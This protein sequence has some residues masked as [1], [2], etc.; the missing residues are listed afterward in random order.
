MFFFYSLSILEGLYDSP[1]LHASQMALVP[2]GILYHPP[3]KFADLVAPLHPIQFQTLWGLRQATVHTLSL[4]A[5]RPQ[6][7][8]LAY[9]A[10]IQL[11]KVENED[12]TLLSAPMA[13]LEAAAISALG[14]E[15][16][17]AW[18]KGLP[19]SF[20]HIDALNPDGCDNDVQANPFGINFTMAAWLHTISKA[21]G[22]VA[23]AKQ[24]YAPYV[25]NEKGWNAK[26][27]AGETAEDIID[28]WTWTPGRSIGATMASDKPALLH[29]LRHSAVG[30]KKM[31]EVLY[32]VH[33]VR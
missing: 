17:R 4:G 24:R 16:W 15:W 14:D 31:L 21:W 20:G 29:T 9:S 8:D 22:F 32:Q 18:Y 6:D 11:G 3:K 5:A 28:S 19:D 1:T 27:E 23:Y 25:N 7:F 2:Q 30:A 12:P 13:K 10:A 33:E 26:I